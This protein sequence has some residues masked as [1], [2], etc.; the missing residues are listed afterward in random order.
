MRTLKFVYP[1][2]PGAADEQLAHN[3]MRDS[4]DYG[5]ADVLASGLILPPPRS[6]TQLLRQYEGPLLVFQGDLDPLNGAADRA[7]RIKMQYPKATVVHV[8]AG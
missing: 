3:I 5:A 4:F 2:N 6:L 8:Q 7:E 1:T